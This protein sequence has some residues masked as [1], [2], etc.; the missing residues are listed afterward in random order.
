[1]V[2]EQALKY[3]LKALREGQVVSSPDTED[4]TPTL[5]D[6]PLT[7]ETIG[8]CSDYQI[9]LPDITNDYTKRAGMINS[10]YNLRELILKMYFEGTSVDDTQT[11]ISKFSSMLQDEILFKP[12]GENSK[13]I[14]DGFYSGELRNVVNEFENNI[15]G[16]FV[17]KVNQM[18]PMKQFLFQSN[19]ETI[20]ITNDSKFPI[21]CM[22]VAKLSSDFVRVCGVSIYNKISS[23]DIVVLDGINYKIYKVSQ[24]GEKIYKE[25]L[26]NCSRMIKFPVLNPGENSFEFIKVES[27]VVQYFPLL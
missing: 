17:F 10:E 14:Y 25:N 1:M 13:L 21:N 16:E 20:S 8:E 27:L 7:L 26:M 23:G 22:I 24:S 18:L 3:A 19:P 2:S 12:E 15:Y 6:V 5:N 11:K 4:K 9:G